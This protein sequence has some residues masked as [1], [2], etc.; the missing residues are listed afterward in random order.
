MTNDEPRHHRICPLIALVVAAALGGCGGAAKSSAPASE[1]PPTGPPCGHGLEVGSATLR[2]DL[3]GHSRLVIVHVPT[4]Y[5]G[6]AHRAL[7]LNLHGSGSTARQQ[8]LLSGMNATA[9]RYSFVVA[10]PQALITSG[11][12][13]DWNVPNEPLSGGGFPPASAADDV[14]FLSD[15]VPAL[16]DHYCIDTR[17]VYATGLSGGGRMVSQLACDAA[18][19]FA[20]VAPVAGLRYPPPCPARRAVP[21]VAFHGTADLID[22]YLGHGGSYWTYSVPTAASEWA[23]REGCLARPRT[24]LGAG[25]TLSRYTRCSAGSAVE[26][27]AVAGEGHEWPGGPHLPTAITSFLGPQSGAVDANATMWSFFDGYRLA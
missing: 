14:T 21:I 22:P 6:A 2:L 24:V 16:A 4:G 10:Y 25:Y 20:A 27:F 23:A 1:A 9:D 8:E 5:S 7:V 13:F 12:G 19:V 26:L 3:D 15:L 18:G 11:N 17:R